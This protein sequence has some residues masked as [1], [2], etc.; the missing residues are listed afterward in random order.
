MTYIGKITGKYIVSLHI[1]GNMRLII[2]R[3]SRYTISASIIIFHFIMTDQLL[4]LIHVT[5][6]YCYITTKVLGYAIMLILNSFAM[7]GWKC[8]TFFYGNIVF[9]WCNVHPCRGTFVFDATWKKN[10]L[11]YHFINSEEHA[12]PAMY[13]MFKSVSWRF[14]LIMIEQY[15]QYH[16][17]WIL[18]FLD[19]SPDE[20]YN[21]RA[22]YIG[23]IHVMVS[24]A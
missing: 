24:V 7:H 21:P 20:C 10:P 13:V 23:K 6:Q 9:E 22:H 8:L 1:F 2:I 3:S 12:Y 16:K 19:I 17:E 11:I 14:T 18:Y 4:L 5:F 15:E